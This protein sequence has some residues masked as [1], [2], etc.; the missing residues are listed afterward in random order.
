MALSS[1]ERQ[2]LARISTQ[3]TAESPRLATSLGEFRLCR[4]SSQ[5]GR[6]ILCV[7]A[8]LLGLALWLFGVWLGSSA[9]VVLTIVGHLVVIAAVAT[10]VPSS[11]W[12]DPEWWI[13][14]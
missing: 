1:Y 14:M 11:W 2:E 13:Y 4:S 5:S 10:G 6:R 3:L 7:L 9:A 12:P 8:I